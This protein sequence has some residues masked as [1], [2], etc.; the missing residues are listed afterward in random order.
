MKEKQLKGKL[1]L[2]SEQGMEGGY[3]S[4]ID[5]KFIDF[6]V[7]IHGLQENR[8][9]YDSKYGLRNGITSNPEMLLKGSWIPL[10]DPML[11]DPDYRISS[12]WLGEERGDFE[13]DKRLMKKYRFKLFYTEDKANQT[14]GVGNWKFTKPYSE[15]QL[16]SGEI[17]M[18]GGTPES[19]PSRPYSIPT[20][21]LVRVT[22]EWSDGTIE[23]KRLSNSL[24]IESWSY[25]GL[26]RLN[27]DDFI[28]VLEPSSEEIICQG[29]VN[30]IPLRIFSQTLE[31][32]F[33]QDTLNWRNFF[34]QGYIAEVIREIKT[35]TNNG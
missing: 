2:H 22:V 27:E 10:R 33:N 20:S 11:D 19:S 32:H 28:K 6:K 30:K 15:I 29:I 34:R 5:I 1:H 8:K 17:I 9:V 3:L 26:H 25:E 4:L 16:N 13:A 12:L 24:Y 18:M 35:T 7:P 31:G 23:E 14:Y 21:D